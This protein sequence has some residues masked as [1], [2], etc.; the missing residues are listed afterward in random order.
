M[1]HCY[2]L[3]TDPHSIEMYSR[4]QSYIERL[5]SN[6]RCRGGVLLS[7]L[8]QICEIIEIIAQ[9]LPDVELYRQSLAQIVSVLGGALL[10]ERTSDEQR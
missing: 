4:H 7:E 6:C 8:I 10:K 1:E 2:K 5:M 3:L 9:R